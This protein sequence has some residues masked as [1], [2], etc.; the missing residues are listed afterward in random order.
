[1]QLQN[2]VGP[3]SVA[4]LG[5]GVP[6]VARAGALGDAIVTELHAPFFEGSARGT[7]FGAANQAAVATS[8]AF[9]TTYTGLVIY[10]PP[11]SNVLLSL[12]KIGVA[13]ILAQTTTLAV[14]LMVGF[15]TVALSGVTALTPRSKRVGGGVNPVGLAAAAATLPVA[16]TLDTLLG[17]IGTGATTVDQLVPSMFLL[18]GDIVLPPGGYA[19]VYTNAAAVAASLLLSAQWE[20][21]PLF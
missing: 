9:A 21:V 16:P 7:R 3:P 18:G 5:P 4:A 12:E 17:Y 14:G 6:V 20:E 10:N 19:A 15:S 8:A 2:N 11:G 13:P 1:M